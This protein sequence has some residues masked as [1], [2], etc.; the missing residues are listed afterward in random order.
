[1]I[2]TVEWHGD[3]LV[4]AVFSQP[5]TW[6]DFYEIVKHMHTLIAQKPHTVHMVI[7]HQANFPPGN[8]LRNFQAAIQDQ[9]P[10]AG[11]IFIIPKD[12][13]S[14]FQSFMKA[15]VSIVEKVNPKMSRIRMVG[16]IAEAEQ[17]AAQARLST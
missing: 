15:L 9:P 11:H 7:I 3:E 14:P 16:S 4:V 10:N 1:M 2:N 12:P 17:I 5:W 8:P 13:H 6:L